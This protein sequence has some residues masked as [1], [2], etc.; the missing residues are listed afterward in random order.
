MGLKF[1]LNFDDS[2][3]VVG[4]HLVG[5]IVGT[6]LIG[7]FSS[8][9]APGGVDG[10]FYGGGVDSLVDQVMAAL[11]AIVWSGVM[12]A[13]IA[14]AIK[15]TIGWRVTD[16]AEVEGIDSDQHGEGA[17]DLHTS[18]SGGGSSLLATKTEA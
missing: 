10:L 8:A 11:I 3:D 17:Y 2:L 14:L 6:V 12:T 15:Y 13:I 7:F 16:E 9:N 18:L 1:K 5:G 4:V